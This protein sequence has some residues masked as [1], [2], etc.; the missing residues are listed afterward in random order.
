[1]RIV[2][3]NIFA[4]ERLMGNDCP[5]LQMKIAAADPLRWQMDWGGPAQLGTGAWFVPQWKLAKGTG[6]TPEWS[7]RAVEE[8]ISIDVPALRPRKA[9]N[10]DCCS[11]RAVWRH[12]CGKE[13]S[14]GL[15]HGG[16]IRRGTTC[17]DPEVRHHRFGTEAVTRLV[18][19]G[20]HYSC[21]DGEYRLLLET[22]VQYPGR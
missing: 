18:E 8:L 10:S 5:P 15:Y 21:G 6:R 19:A 11:Y 4:I 2:W 20:G 16:A 14:G 7:Y 3:T 12:R 1:M 17:G 9:D 22:G 13:V